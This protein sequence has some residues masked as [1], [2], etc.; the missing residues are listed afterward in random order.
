LNSIQSPQFQSRA[1]VLA[2]FAHTA[3]ALVLLLGHKYVSSVP[4][5]IEFKPLE[6]IIE[7]DIDL[8]DAP[9]NTRLDVSPEELRQGVVIT[10]APTQIKDGEI[11]AAP[12]VKSSNSSGRFGGVM[13]L[14]QGLGKKVVTGDRNQS[15]Q[16]LAAEQQQL[17]LARTSKSVQSNLDNLSG[18]SGGGDTSGVR[19]A[20]ILPK[21]VEGIQFTK[22]QKPDIKPIANLTN[23]ELDRVRLMFDRK[24]IEIRDCYETAL[25]VDEKL[26]G[27]INLQVQVG[28]GGAV[29][30][31]ILDF[32]GEGDPN[33]QRTLKSCVKTVVES[34]QF[35]EKLNGQTLQLGYRLT[36]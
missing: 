7:G 32:K 25:Q 24:W 15:Q 17:A 8:E 4:A 27:Y 34:M 9:S 20:R 16:K 14:T 13:S 5:K 21:R 3:F 1:A 26:S 11:P 18:N 31:T 10:N 29:K 19:A 6:V 35:F 33:S 22:I 28:G 36:I 23:E 30:Q 12:Q 2:F